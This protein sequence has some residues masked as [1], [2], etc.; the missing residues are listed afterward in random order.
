MR[1]LLALY[2]GEVMRMRRYGIAGASMV[3][4]VLWVLVLHYAGAGS[5]DMVFPLVLFA[6]ATFMSFLLIGVIMIF[7]KQEGATKSMLV[8]PI[9]KG[10]YLGAKVL[11]TITSSVVTLVLLLIY[12]LAFRDLSINI[13]GIF[14]AVVLSAFAFCQVGLVITYRVRD[15][16]QLLMSMFAFTMVFAVPTL[17]EFLH[18]LQGE[19]I[20]RVQY[21]NPTKSA[22]NVLMAPAGHVAAADLWISAA[23]LTVLGIGLAWV[24]WRRFD[25]YAAKEIGG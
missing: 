5:I 1:E 17:L 4:V 22:L 25:A 9:G 15:F 13:P 19:W 10:G 8:L 14:A 20:T 7:E 12:G 23:Y 18:I 21:L 2:S 3:V 6:D 16:T 24:A 11:A